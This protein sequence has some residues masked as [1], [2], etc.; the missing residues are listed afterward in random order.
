MEEEISKK[1][2]LRN[3]SAAGAMLFGV[4]TFLTVRFFPH[5]VLWRRNL[6]SAMNLRHFGQ[7]GKLFPEITM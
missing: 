1:P 4:I 2:I 7:I 6:P 5:R 3:H